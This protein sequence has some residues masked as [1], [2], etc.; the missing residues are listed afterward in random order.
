[1]K[2]LPA[3]ALACLPLAASA[4]P[5]PW[6]TIQKAGGLTLGQPF[7]SPD[8]WLLL[9]RANLAP[10]NP[11]PPKPDSWIACKSTSAVVE[12]S[13]IYLTVVSTLARYRVGAVCPAAKIGEIESG[14]YT[15]FYRGPGEPPVR[16]S[17]VQFGR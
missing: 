5:E 11:N 17:D 4:G 15:V 8:G 13:N 9:V 10:L 2:I 3:L 12:G 14:T 1:M 6:G 7:H 16:L